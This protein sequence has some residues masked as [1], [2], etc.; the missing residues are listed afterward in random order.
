MVLVKLRQE[1]QASHVALEQGLP[2]MAP[3]LSRERYVA[4]L[5][6]FYGFYAPV[7]RRVS[8][9][10]DPASWPD[11]LDR[12]KVGLLER[13]LLCLGHAAGDLS[14]LPRCPAVPRAPSRAAELGLMYVLEGATLGGQLIQRHVKAVL[15]LDAACGCAF[16]ASYGRDAGAMWRSFC[17]VLERELA[18]GPQQDEA[19]VAAR[20]TFDAL[21]HWLLQEQA[22]V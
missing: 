2:L 22:G 1:T 5:R 12:R 11:G 6:R 7:E 3:D 14:G 16:F 13:D 15:G 4:L 19:V 17:G 8:A 9:Y 10:R 21:R 18:T 20:E